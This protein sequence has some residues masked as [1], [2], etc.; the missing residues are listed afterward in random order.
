MMAKNIEQIR[1]D[2]SECES[3]WLYFWGSGG[4]GVFTEKPVGFSAQDAER[5]VKFERVQE[6]T[7][8]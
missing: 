3:V 7:N 5:L 4:I 1:K 8:D 6:K 2:A